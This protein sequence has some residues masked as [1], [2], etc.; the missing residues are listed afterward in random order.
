MRRTSLGALIVVAC[1]IM[2]FSAMALVPGG[3]SWKDSYS[4]EGQCYC[5][6][7]FDHHIGKVIVQTPAGEKTVAEVCAVI[8]PGPGAAG[9]PIYNDI[10]CGNGPP[11]DQADEVECPGRV[12]MG[13]AGCGIIGPRWNL[14]RYFAESEPEQETAGSAQK[15]AQPQPAQPNPL[16]RSSD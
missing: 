12:D 6:T 2:S 9:N 4:F 7:T 5:D 14:E 15:R 1:V 16:E 13:E 8:G 3:A 11:N 10:Q